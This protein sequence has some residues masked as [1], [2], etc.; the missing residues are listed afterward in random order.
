MVLLVL[1][2]AVAVAVYYRYSP[3][4]GGQRFGADDHGV[5]ASAD[6]KLH[7]S[8]FRR[9]LD[10]R[11]DPC[12]DFDAYVCSLW[13]P[14]SGLARDLVE[15]MALSWALKA[16]RFLTKETSGGR[17][18]ANGSFAHDQ[19]E[20]V[21]TGRRAAAA[22][23]Q[24][25]IAQ[26]DDDADSLRMVRHFAASIGIPWPYDESATRH[27]AHPFAVL[28][29]LDVL[30]GLELWSQASELPKRLSQ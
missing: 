5:C 9:R 19:E 8:F 1:A 10:T 2:V 14:A 16:A 12:A 13:S 4:S 7:A 30:W 26:K 3:L 29:K 23:V 24:K 11:I 20:A 18:D 6:C 22:F 21:S 15:E 28:G 25:C 27:S 17:Y